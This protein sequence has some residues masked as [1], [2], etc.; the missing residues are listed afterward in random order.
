MAGEVYVEP[1]GPSQNARYEASAAMILS[2]DLMPA[3]RRSTF[4][5]AVPSMGKLPLPAIQRS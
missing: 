2:A 1:G 3:R 4:G 5:L